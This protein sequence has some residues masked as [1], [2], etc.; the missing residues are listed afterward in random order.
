MQVLWLEVDNFET[1][2]LSKVMT[3]NNN[4]MKIDIKA[5]Y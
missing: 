1:R 2:K 3:Q 5:L 4:Y